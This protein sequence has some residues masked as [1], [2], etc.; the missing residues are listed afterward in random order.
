MPAQA[1]LSTKIKSVHCSTKGIIL[2]SILNQYLNKYGSNTATI[3]HQSMPRIR[4]C[5]LWLGKECQRCSR[6]A[7]S[8]CMPCPFHPLC[9]MYAAGLTNGRANART[10][11]LVCFHDLN[12]PQLLTRKL[13]F[14]YESQECIPTAFV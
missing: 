3:R 2:I 1:W 8:H 14:H 10:V 11:C 4:E 9:V 12:T 6:L 5:S 13:A 7:V